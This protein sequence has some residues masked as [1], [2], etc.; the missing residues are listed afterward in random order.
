MEES[1]ERGKLSILQ[2]E[3]L[4]LDSEVKRLEQEIE[5]LRLLNKKNIDEFYHLN[6][7]YMML[8]E[9]KILTSLKFFFKLKKVP[10]SFKL[11]I[12]GKRHWKQL[13][14]Q[15]WKINRV[16]KRMKK[17]RY[18][19]HEL[20]FTHTVLSELQHFVQFSDDK[21]LVRSAA[22]E[23]AQWYATMQ[24]EYAT[25]ALHYLSIAKK[26]EK[27]KE[28][29]RELSILEAFII[30]ESVNGKQN[31][32]N[33]IARRLQQ[34][35][36]LAAANMPKSN[37]KANNAPVRKHFD[38]I[39]AS[40]FRL[41]GGTNMSNV[42][43]IKAQKSAGLTTGLIQ[44]CRYDFES[45]KEMNHRV[46]DLI[47]GEKVQLI[48]YGES[49]S[50]DVLIVRHPPVLQEWQ[51]YLPEIDAKSVKVIVNQPPKRDYGKQGVTLYN[52][53]Q[54]AANLY[55]Y[56]GSK[57]KW[58]PIGPQ[59]RETLIQYHSHEL[60]HIKLS[61]A[62][63]VNIINVNEWKRV[64]RPF[65]GSVIKIG[66][67][68]RSQYVKWPNSKNDLLELYPTTSKYEVHVLGGAE[69]PKKLLGSIPENWKVLEFGDMEPKDFLKG[70][71]VFVY[72]THPDWVEA[73][74]RVI[75]EAMAV[76]VPVI[77]HP[78]YKTLFGNAA[79][80]AEIHEVQDKI[81]ELMNND[82]LYIKQVKIAHDFVEKHFGY[83]QH[84]SRL[85]NH[86][87][88]LL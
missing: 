64:T 35:H 78:K 65:K 88:K 14:T 6:R 23:L 19:L 44:M 29:L 42:E 2:E 66:R 47:D 34:D 13:F 18:K 11:Y 80:Y 74:G 5:E 10:S 58:Y 68:S 25:Y 73:F 52:L 46:R 86:L 36:Y 87:L 32:S 51:R 79:I 60:K 26:G 77:I 85:S 40:E 53:K 43:E 12:T 59:V 57:G 45:Q 49:V 27:S 16:E 41:Q 84:I 67:H 21:L 15:K 9:S 39:I 28:K 63:W 31:I 81:T 82:E 1:N 30:G 50:C 8:K 76:G 61:D 17:Y 33:A 75:F 54:C 83:S 70:L 3:N 56:T 22:F 72:Y 69:S 7:Q 71:D 48:V 55:E 24:E 37:L 62:N 38:V 20:G 4:E